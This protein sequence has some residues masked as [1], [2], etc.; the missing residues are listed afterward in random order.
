MED[1]IIDT[2]GDARSFI[3]KHSFLLFITAS[4][5]ISAVV[6]YI[7]MQMY[8]SSGAAQLDLSRPGYVSVRSQVD[9]SDSDLQTYPS[10]GVISKDVINSFKSS[11]NKQAKK[12]E[13]VD[14][15]GGDPLDPTALGISDTSQQ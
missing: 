10:S 4:I 6:V 5:V 15:F 9:T 14:A 13:T 8:N 2:I 11:F 12:I 3:V 7:S 1:K